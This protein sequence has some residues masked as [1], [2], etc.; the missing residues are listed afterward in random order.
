MFLTRFQPK[1]CAT[2]SNKK[3]VRIERYVPPGAIRSM[4]IAG[5]SPGCCQTQV[6]AKTIVPCLCTVRSGPAAL[7]PVQPP[8]PGP[9]VVAAVGRDFAG[10]G[11]NTLF[12]SLND[13]V[14]WS[15]ALGLKF[16]RFPGDV[17]RSGST[18]IAVGQDANLPGGTTILRSSD[19]I[20]WG[21]VGGTQ[22]T[23][24][25]TGIAG[26][27]VGV[28]VATGTN[29]S[30]LYSTD[31][32]LTW[33]ASGV[34]GFSGS[35]GGI[36]YASGQWIASSGGL[37]RSLNGI[38]WTP[39]VGTTFA[40]SGGS[41][42]AIASG[43]GRFVAVGNDTPSLAPNYTIVTST[44]GVTWSIAPSGSFTGG[45][46]GG[47]GVDYSPQQT[48]W[49]AGGDGT[50]PILVSS[51][52]VNWSAAGVTGISTTIL[53][54]AWTGTRW[55]AV[56][57]APSTIHWSLDGYTWVAAGGTVPLSQAVGVGA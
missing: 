17:A 26:N 27:G 37:V 22:F 2:N 53:N 29:P 16:T 49:V 46:L 39:C 24:F 45:T 35:G 33:T 42:S 30:L 18:W 6:I 21:S 55:I 57:L 52:G 56:G 54:I 44:D 31:D 51:D 25:G 41:A 5:A 34:T 32:G 38:N 28:W 8:A 15:A 12:Y 23:S 36:L 1:C 48:R 10:A 14:T 7:A 43:N 4:Q 3:P 20:T 9:V 19:G 11:G 47:M 50:T 13:G 40:S